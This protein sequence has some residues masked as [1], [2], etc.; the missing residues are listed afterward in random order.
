M[1]DELQVEEKIDEIAETTVLVFDKLGDY[2]SLIA[3][4]LYLVVGAMLVIYV[5]H[6]LAGKFIY[7]HIKNKRFIRVFFGTLYIFVLVVMALLILERIGVPV[8]GVAA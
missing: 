4:S 3:G 7:P 5:V 8:Q 1:V 2:G 6:R